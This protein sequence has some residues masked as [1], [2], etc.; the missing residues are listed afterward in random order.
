MG[1]SSVTSTSPTHRLSGMTSVTLRT[2]P[3]EAVTIST[4]VSPGLVSI[5]SLTR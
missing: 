2:T 1:V 5:G 3:V 4:A